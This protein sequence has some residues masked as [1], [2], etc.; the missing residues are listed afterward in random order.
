MIDIVKILLRLSY[1][2]WLIFE[3]FG[4]KYD[5]KKVCFV[6]F[7]N[8]NFQSTFNF[9]FYKSTYD[10]GNRS[11]Y[12]LVFFDSSPNPRSYHSSNILVLHY[13]QMG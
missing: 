13:E 2:L 4:T 6:V 3:L 11:S 9:T 1:F 8:S 12:Q 5:G 7:I 10:L